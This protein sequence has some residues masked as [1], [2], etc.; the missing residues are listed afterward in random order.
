MLCHHDLTARKRGKLHKATSSEMRIAV[1]CVIQTRPDYRGASVLTEKPNQV[2]YIALATAPR[3]LTYPS[4]SFV[5]GSADI[6][7]SKSSS[8]VK[9]DYLK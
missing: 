9:L 8:G 6:N 1:C 5:S 7:S 3:L 2:I 4:L